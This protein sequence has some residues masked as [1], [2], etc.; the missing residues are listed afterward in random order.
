MRSRNREVNIFNMSLLDILCG[1]LGAFCFLMLALFP[2]H[3]RVKELEARLSAS[4]G[5]GAEERAKEAERKADEAE[6]KAKTARAEQTL[7]YFRIFWTAPI[8]VDIW[9]QRKDGKICASKPE[10]L[11]AEKRWDCGKVGDATTG[12]GEEQVWFVDVA[13]PGDEYRVFARLQSSGG[14]SALP[15]VRGTIAARVPRGE[16]S[17]MKVVDLP[18]VAFTQAG[19]PIELGRVRFDAENFSIWFGP[20]L[21]DASK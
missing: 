13:Y 21:P 9:L 1:A 10:A 15:G 3:A 7:A 18:E 8:D 17:V 6:K 2:D 19:E 20:K 16:N 12:P 14:Q 4:G 5:M 11:P